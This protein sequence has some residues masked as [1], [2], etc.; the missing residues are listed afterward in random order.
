MN[1]DQT[2]PEDRLDRAIDA[3]LRRLFTPPPAKLPAEVGEQTS[4]TTGWMRIGRRWPLAAVLPI[5]PGGAVRAV[6]EDR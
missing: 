4:G 6:V 1:E 3:S 5:M 2:Q